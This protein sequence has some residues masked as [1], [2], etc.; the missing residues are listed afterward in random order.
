M[1]SKNNSKELLEIELENLE[2][3]LA[4][5]IEQK[6]VKEINRLINACQ[7][8][9]EAIDE[10]DSLIDEPIVGLEIDWAMPRW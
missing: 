1:L 10:L 7:W 5:A 6:R 8:H 2:L 3:V 4:L 9:R